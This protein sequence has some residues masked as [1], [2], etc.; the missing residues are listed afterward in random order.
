G[1]AHVSSGAIDLFVAKLNA[2][3]D[4]QWFK[5]GGGVG[6]DRGIKLAVGPAGT[7][8]VV[9][10]VMG[11]ATP[12]GAPLSSAGGTTDMFVAV[13]NKSDGALQWIRQGGGADGADRP[14]GV[15]VAADGRVAVVGEFRG[16]ATWEGS[17]LTSMVDGSGL[18]SVDVFVA[19]YAPNGDL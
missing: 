3:G 2:A 1:S 18:P 4:V 8:A 15:S 6:I 11:D 17:S 16:T 7:I 5:Q 14:A 12:F 10:E 13:L 9:G 19:N